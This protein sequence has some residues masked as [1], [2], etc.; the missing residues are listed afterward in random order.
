MIN[1]CGA[2]TD[3]DHVSSGED[4]LEEVEQVNIDPSDPVR[5]VGIGTHL[6]AEVRE[7]LVAFL[8]ANASTFAWKTEDMKGIDPSVTSHELNVDSTH[9]PVKQKRRKL[10]PER[11]FIES[12]IDH[13]S[14]VPRVAGQPGSRK[15]EEREV[16]RLR[17]FHRPQQSVPQRQLSLAAHRS[18][19]RSDGGQRTPVFHGPLLRV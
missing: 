17:G 7:E 16:V 9:R 1:L 19:S 2:T 10:G 11:T 18:S 3:I 4:R 13:R 14:K 15:E 5:C 6:K 12:R 8:K